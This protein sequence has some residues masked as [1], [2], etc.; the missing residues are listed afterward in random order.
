[1]LGS[2]YKKRPSISRQSICE[3]FHGKGRK[4]QGHGLIVLITICLSFPASKIKQGPGGILGGQP[5]PDI[6]SAADPRPLLANSYL[7]FVGIAAHTGQRFAHM[8]CC[9]TLV[10]P[11]QPHQTL[12]EA[13]K[14]GQR[15]LL[16]GKW[17]TERPSEI[18]K[19]KHAAGS[20]AR[21]RVIE[22]KRCQVFIE[23]LQLCF[24]LE[25]F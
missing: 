4:T 18:P 21:K 2:V 3:L 19:R 7:S 13:H 10:N 14:R 5:D 23:K 15:S 6:F 16:Y 11:L 20:R 17:T 22:T 9:F 24:L 12:P 25:S 1:M 8:C